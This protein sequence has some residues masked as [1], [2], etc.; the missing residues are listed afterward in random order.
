MRYRVLGFVTV[1]LIAVV[2]APMYIWFG[3]TSSRSGQDFPPAW[4][5]Y[6]VFVLT[7]SVV[8]G[9]DRL[10]R[11]LRTPGRDHQRRP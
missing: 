4:G 6:I 7:A 11:F 1:T 10:V 5:L 8:F 9:A 3:T 2:T